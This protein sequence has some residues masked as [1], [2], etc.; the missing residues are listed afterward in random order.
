MEND[1][2][3]WNEIKRA[4]GPLFQLNPEFQSIKMLKNKFS[5]TLPSWKI[6][7]PFLDHLSHVFMFFGQILYNQ[8]IGFF[9]VSS[10]F[11]YRPP[12]PG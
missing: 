7:K 10:P 8:E 9:N 11:L 1:V 3:E 12:Y 5:F 6:L 4:C 2:V